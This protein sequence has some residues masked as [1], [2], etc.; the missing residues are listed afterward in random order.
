MCF[1]RFI[2]QFRLAA[3]LEGCLFFRKFQ[4]GCLF[5]KTC[6]L[7]NITTND[8]QFTVQRYPKG[9]IKKGKIYFCINRYEQIIYKFIN[10]T[11]LRTK[12]VYPLNLFN[13]RKILLILSKRKDSQNPNT[14]NNINKCK[15]CLNKPIYIHFF[16]TYLKF[17]LFFHK[18]LRGSIFYNCFTKLK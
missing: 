1:F 18:T 7:Y 10:V 3:C 14:C 15:L 12:N 4:P 5:K 2:G 11:V 6:I 8:P 9:E 13:Q 17:W 16:P